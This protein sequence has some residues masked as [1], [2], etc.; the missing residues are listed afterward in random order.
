VDFHLRKETSLKSYKP[1]NITNHS[2]Q[3]ILMQM[4]RVP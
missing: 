3:M 1:I 2:Y 4:V